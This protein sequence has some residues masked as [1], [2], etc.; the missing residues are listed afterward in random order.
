MIILI[1]SGG[2]VFGENTMFFVHVY[3]KVHYYLFFEQVPPE[4]HLEPYQTFKMDN[5]R[6]IVKGHH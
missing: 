4:V 6:K 3:S 1:I 2:E 5:F